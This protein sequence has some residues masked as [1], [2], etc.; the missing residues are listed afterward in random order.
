MTAQDITIPIT[1]NC[2]REQLPATTVPAL[3]HKYSQREMRIYFRKQNM[4]VW[5]FCGGQVE[6]IFQQYFS[7]SISMTI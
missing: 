5:D 2:L 3:K 1:L 7:F 4:A 6:N